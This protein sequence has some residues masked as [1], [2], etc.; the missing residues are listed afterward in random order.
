MI[1]RMLACLQNEKKLTIQNLYLQQ[2]KEA[3]ERQVNSYRK[4]DTERPGMQYLYTTYLREREGLM[5]KINELL[6]R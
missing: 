2:E 6:D 5:I 1:K 3:L 4:P